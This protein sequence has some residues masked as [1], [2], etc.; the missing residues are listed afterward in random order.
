MSTGGG[1]RTSTQN[2]A[3]TT[4]WPVRRSGAPETLFVLGAVSGGGAG[5]RI[6]SLVGRR[7]AHAAPFDHIPHAERNAPPLIAHGAVCI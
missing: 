5:F 1:A 4:H 3:G 2:W 7:A 6:S